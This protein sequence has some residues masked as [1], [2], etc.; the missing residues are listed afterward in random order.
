MSLLFNM[1]FRLITGVLPRSR[2]L[3]ISWLQSPSAV[4]LE[5]PKI[6][7]VTVSTVSSSICHEVMGPDAM[8]LLFWMLSFKPAFPLFSFTCIKRLFNSLLS[9]IRVV[10]SALAINSK[11]TV[12][13]NSGSSSSK[14]SRLRGGLWEPL[15]FISQG[16]RRVSLPHKGGCWIGE[17]LYTVYSTTSV[18]TFCFPSQQV[19]LGQ[20]WLQK[21]V[22]Y[23]GYLW[24][25]LFQ[26]FSPSVY[27]PNIW[28]KETFFAFG[29]CQT[30]LHSWSAASGSV[31]KDRFLI[32]ARSGQVSPGLQVTLM[33]ARLG[34]LYKTLLQ[35]HGQRRSI[36]YLQTIQV[37]LPIMASKRRAY[38]SSL[39]INLGEITR[40]VAYSVKFYSFIQ[41]TLTLC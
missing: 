3:L 26:C 10:S 41:Q 8:I 20:V 22:S 39:W 4:I 1:L 13:L 15:Q 24:I 35:V 34:I 9:A 31:W 36:S 2:R 33:C 16:R 6:K 19:V 17:P 12:F 18:P 37:C 27:F 23:L 5:P 14:P 38:V 30:V 28:V 32:P 21:M 29:K 11:E 25:S 7:S 40:V